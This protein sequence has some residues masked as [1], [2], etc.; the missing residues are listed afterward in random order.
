MPSTK[1]EDLITVCL[2]ALVII[3]ITASAFCVSSLDNG[4]SQDP[5]NLRHLDSADFQ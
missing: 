4:T 2:S 5:R 3:L 1:R